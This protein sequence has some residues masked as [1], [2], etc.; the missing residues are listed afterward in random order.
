MLQWQERTGH[1]R[2]QSIVGV[3][4]FEIL[5]FAISLEAQK[6]VKKRMHLYRCF[7]MVSSKF[8]P[9]SD[10]MKCFKAYVWL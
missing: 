2:F 6:A 5:G 8:F 3:P 9:T 7:F 1:L 10:A 4:S